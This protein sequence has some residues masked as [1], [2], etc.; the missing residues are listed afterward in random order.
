MELIFLLIKDL[1]RVQRHSVGP[2]ETGSKS[3]SSKYFTSL[4]IRKNMPVWCSAYLWQALWWQNWLPEAK[5]LLEIFLGIF[6][7]SVITYLL[8]TGGNVLL[9]LKIAE[10]SNSYSFHNH[11]LPVLDSIPFQTKVFSNE[12]TC[13]LLD[14]RH[15]TV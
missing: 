13:Q 6:V 8:I 7:W 3:P 12:R 4:H 5:Y 9:C 2:L 11:F 14:K 15:L 10:V 1:L